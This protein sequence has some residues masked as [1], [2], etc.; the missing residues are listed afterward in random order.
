[1]ILGF[2]GKGGSGKSTVATLMS[3][4]LHT[5]G[6]TVLAVDAD[7]NMDLAYNLGYD[8]NG[9][10]IGGTFL[11]LRN[12][13]GLNDTEP[14]E[15][16][17]TKSAPDVRFS[18]TKPDAYSAE[19]V[20]QLSERLYLMMSGPQHEL[21]LHGAHCSHSLAAPLKVY[22]PLLK[23]A[24]DEVVVVDEKASVDAVSTGIPTGF[25]LAVVVTEPRVHSLRSGKQIA[26][27]LDWYGVPRIVVLNKHKSAAD[28]EAF[29]EVFGE[30]PFATL[31]A[32][33]DQDAAN[34]ETE[35]ALA[36][37]AV[38]AA[39]EAKKSETGRLERTV[40]KY[41]RNEEFQRTVA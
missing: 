12:Q 9:P 20:H 24:P 41:R 33:L 25:D 27:M 18:F 17:F 19:Y 7:H 26:E 6:K 1:M 15:R 16:I 39:Q 14:T 4:H 23:L 32:T 3:R 40:A 35:R 34:A 5:A 28:V 11:P 36:T 37:I 21:V 13:F 8:G 2:L 38:E 30:T 22:L 31:P 10:Y 29:T